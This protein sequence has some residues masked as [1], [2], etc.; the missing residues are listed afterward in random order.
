MIVDDFV[1]KIKRKLEAMKQD[2]WKVDDIEQLIS[3]IERQRAALN[4]I[5]HVGE[6]ESSQRAIDALAIELIP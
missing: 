3:I 1:T 2:G 6:Y 4:D 5:A